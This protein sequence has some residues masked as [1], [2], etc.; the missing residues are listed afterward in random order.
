MNELALHCTRREPSTLDA[1]RFPM[2]ARWVLRLLERIEH[3]R[4]DIVFPDGQRAR[5]GHGS[6]HAD[7]ELANW[8]VFGATLKSGDIGFAESYLAG[9]WSTS[10]PA[11]LLAFFLRNRAAVERV[12]YGSFLG[13]LLR[14]ARKLLH[15]NTRAR[16][17]RN[18]HA[19][20]DLGN[21]FY[22]LW[23]DPSMTYS[24]ALFAVHADST[25]DEASLAAG[26]RAKY[27]RVLDEL[28]LPPRSRVLEIGCGW[29]G[30]AELAAGAGHDLTGI[31]L[32]PSQLAYAGE[33]LQRANLRADLQLRDYRDVAG[34]YDGVASIEMFEAV[35]EAYWQSFFATLART[36]KRG[37][38]A[39]VQTITIRNDLFERY[40][41]GTDFVQ[42]YI[43]P[44]G[45]LPSPD[46]FE[47]QA[48][49]A[50]LRIENCLSFG[51]DYATTLAA[52]RARFVTR[53]DAVRVLG[54]DNHFIRLWEFY[55]GY[56]EAA[57]AEG[58]TDVVQFTLAAR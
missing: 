57:F 55:L 52:W 14:R 26:Q 35:G 29:G 18:V 22:A 38:R 43:F 19:H 48:S 11:K 15:R 8:N 13:C 16:A 50:G 41:S 28:R 54:F 58:N 9:D 31:T 37:A 4:L 34:E 6:P 42:Q 27:H 21:A 7:I 39:C 36:L 33:R 5:Y 3:G 10:D 46:A 25:P 32:S 23:L 45:M 56:C 53:L 44:G 49:A 24:S 40:R 12:I 2:Q 47:R 51:R 30:F 20:Y 17:K 1:S